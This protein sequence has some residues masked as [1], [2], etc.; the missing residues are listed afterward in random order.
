M[1]EI[2]STIQL[3]WHWEIQASFGYNSLNGNQTL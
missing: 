3:G 2:L 1:I